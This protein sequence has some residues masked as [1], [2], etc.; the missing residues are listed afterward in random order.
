METRRKANRA[1]D[2]T[3]FQISIGL[4][5]VVCSAFIGSLGGI[6]MKKM[7]P[8]TG[9]QVQPARIVTNALTN[10]GQFRVFRN[11]P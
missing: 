11:A 6:L 10:K 7:P 8:L 9:L 2:P 1:F 5:F 3:S 4:M